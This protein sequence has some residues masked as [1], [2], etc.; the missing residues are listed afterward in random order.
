MKCIHK[1]TDNGSL[2]GLS[3]C[4]SRDSSLFAEHSMNRPTMFF[5]IKQLCLF[6]GLSLGNHSFVYYYGITFVRSVSEMNMCPKKIE[7]I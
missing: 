2:A 5:Y 4:T 3:L 7:I 1:A 6:G